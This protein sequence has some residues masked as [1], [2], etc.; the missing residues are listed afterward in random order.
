M[1]LDLLSRRL[2]KDFHMKP[3]KNVKSMGHKPE[4]SDVLGRHLNH[5]TMALLPANTHL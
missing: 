4:I 1:K 3:A 2:I 5:Q